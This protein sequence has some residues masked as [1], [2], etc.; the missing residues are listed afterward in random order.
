MKQRDDDERRQDDEHEGEVQR[1]ERPE[2]RAGDL[3][4]VELSM[5]GQDPHLQVEGALIALAGRERRPRR[6]VM[7]GMEREVVH[8]VAGQRGRRLQ[9]EDGGVLF[10]LQGG[11]R[12][13]DA[14]LSADDALAVDD[15]R[16]GCRDPQQE[17]GHQH[18]AAQDAPEFQA[19]QDAHAVTVI[20][21]RHSA[22][23]RP[24]SQTTS[25]AT[26]AARSR[27][28]SHGDGGR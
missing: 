16:R 26:P 24:A 21:P 10:A 27:H 2:E 7:P 28:P 1:A 9:V 12:G 13:E 23:A 22:T 19:K 11:A 8:L 25:A 14:L 18:P 15:G 5:Q 6:R 3:P 4:V 17:R 20:R